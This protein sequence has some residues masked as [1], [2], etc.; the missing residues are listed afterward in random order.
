[1]RDR[2]GYR[3]KFGVIAPSTNT[4]VEPEFHQM[5]V[6]GV[7]PHFGR[8]H[9]RCGSIGSDEEMLALLAQ[10]REEMGHCIDRLL[11]S[12]PDSLVMGMSAET[13]WD[14][15]EGNRRFT[16]E[17][18]ERSG[19][20]SVATGAEAACVNMA[21]ILVVENAKTLSDKP[22]AKRSPRSR[23]KVLSFSGS[24]PT[25]FWEITCICC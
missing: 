17:V 13:F 3:Q 4:I 16:A 14:G 11:T 9:I 8:I 7:T 2:L 15:L 25:G 6:P 1:M 22:V 5:R 24:I 10:I 18:S 20:L 23:T 19:G 21:A 12:E